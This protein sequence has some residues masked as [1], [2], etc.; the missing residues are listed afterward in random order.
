M[1]R[2]SIVFGFTE[3]SLGLALAAASSTGI[4]A[5]FLGDARS[6]LLLA[7]RQRFPQDELVEGEG[8]FLVQL[9]LV[10]SFIEQPRLERKFGIDV[11]GTDFQR[12]VWQALRDI[13]PGS[14]VSYAQIARRIGRP[15]SVRAVAGA[16]AANKIA[17]AIPCHRVLRSDGDIS[18]YRWGVERKRKL[19]EREAPGAM[20][21]AWLSPTMLSS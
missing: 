19:L 3:T 9:S 7:L 5:I 11:Q 12:Q 20:A 18:G 16:C 21:Q 4:C 6:S 17:V 14:T 15:R 13:P 1:D 2:R 10:A 8:D